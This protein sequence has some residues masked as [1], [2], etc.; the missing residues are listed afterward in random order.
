MVLTGV[1]PL[2]GHS[3]YNNILIAPGPIGRGDSMFL[4]GWARHGE[5]KEN[6]V[7]S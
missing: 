7:D 6:L 3:R 5:D 2:V 1:K 4:M